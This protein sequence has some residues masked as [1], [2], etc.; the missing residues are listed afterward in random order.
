RRSARHSAAPV[1]KR[2]AADLRLLYDFRSAHGTRLAPRPVRL[3]LR[4]GAARPLSRV[5]HT[6]AAGALCG[7]V[8]ARADDA[9]ARPVRSR[10]TI[11]LVT[12]RPGSFSMTRTVRS[13][14]KA[15]V[16]VAAVCAQLAVCVEPASA[17]CGFYVA[18][19]DAKMF[20]KSS[21]VVLARN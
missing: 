15:S 2:L 12:N 20:N 7:S 6:D 16:A 5:L 18:K 11:C 3:R 10:R 4:R 17:F 19:A 1:A 13:R 9:C 8:C 14:L 21:K